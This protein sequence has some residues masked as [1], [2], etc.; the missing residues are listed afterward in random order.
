MSWVA[1]DGVVIIKTNYIK[2]Y[3]EQAGL[4]QRKLAD[5]TGLSKGSIGEMENHKTPAS[6]SDL[7]RIARALKISK[8]LL[9]EPNN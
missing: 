9:T 7:Y 1:Q 2:K 4:S 5:L 8:D 6:D 3:R